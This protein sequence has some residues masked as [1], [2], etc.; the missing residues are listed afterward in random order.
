MV[1]KTK[2]STCYRIIV[3]ALC[4]I[5]LGVAIPK[6]AGAAAGPVRVWTLSGYRVQIRT[7]HPH[8]FG[9]CVRTPVK[10]FH[11]EVF[12]RISGGRYEYVSNF[13]VGIYRSA[14]GRKCYVVWNNHRPALCM[15][16]CNMSQAQLRHS[17]QS[18]LVAIGV[19]VAIAVTIAALVAVA[20]P[21]LLL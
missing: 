2:T 10:H 16:T 1:T 21:V 18:A 8:C 3:I 14:N 17:I 13:H 5:V 4:L 11:V 12:K 9:A 15:K 20:A 7:D 19:A 6:S